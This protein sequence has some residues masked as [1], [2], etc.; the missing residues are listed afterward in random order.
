MWNKQRSCWQLQNHVWVTNFRRRNRKITMLGKSEYLFVV[1]RHGRSCHEMC[2]TIL[3]VGEQNDSTTL[4][5]IN[6]MHWWPSFQ[7]RRNE[8]RGR[9]VK[10]ICSQNV[11]N[12][13]YLA[14]IGRPDILWSVKKSCTINYSK[15]TTG[16]WQTTESRFISYIQSHKCST[17]N[18]VMWETL[19]RQCRLGLFQ[20]SDFAGDL[21]D[22]KS[23]SGGTLSFWKSYICSDKLDV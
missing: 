11:L 8:I 12:F 21:E 13:L 2:G 17:N 1:L 15:W 18:I 7:R 19:P 20:D 22:L 5:S 10:K 23:I 3:W 9:V 16:M 6:S 4:Q 14:R